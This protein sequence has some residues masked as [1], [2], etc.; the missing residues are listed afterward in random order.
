MQQ[1]GLEADFPELPH[2]NSSNSKITYPSR[3]FFYALNALSHP[4]IYD[5]LIV[6]A[7]NSC[8][9]YVKLKENENQGHC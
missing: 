9:D 2:V 8:L 4:F 6:W 1:G 7:W 3:E 5:Y